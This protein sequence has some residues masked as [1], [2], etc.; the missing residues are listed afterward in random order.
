MSLTMMLDAPHL[1]IVFGIADPDIVTD[2]CH[3]LGI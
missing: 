2:Y 3:L 1:A